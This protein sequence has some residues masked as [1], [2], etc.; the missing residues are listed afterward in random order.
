MS[1]V[2]PSSAPTFFALIQGFRRDV[3]Y[4]K[5][6]HWHFT[7]ALCYPRRPS[8]E[9]HL[10][11]KF[12]HT[13]NE[14]LVGMEAIIPRSLCPSLTCVAQKKTC[15]SI[16]ILECCAPKGGV[17]R[18]TDQLHTHGLGSVPLQVTPYSCGMPLYVCFF[19]LSQHLYHNNPILFDVIIMRCH[20][21]PHIFC[22]Y[23]RFLLSS[24][25]CH[26]LSEVVIG[27]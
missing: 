23:K 3:N 9:F 25:L 10:N 5:S 15:V 1:V 4:T 2:L 12:H 17:F 6:T 20:I 26:P 22:L 7:N 18:A 14:P 24:I 21:L 16:L 13:A 11:R 27:I 19:S 8:K